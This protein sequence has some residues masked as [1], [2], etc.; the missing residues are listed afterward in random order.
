[1]NAIRSS[2]QAVFN[3]TWCI[4][5]AARVQYMQYMQVAPVHIFANIIYMCV[6]IN[7]N[8]NFRAVYNRY[9]GHVLHRIIGI[10]CIP[11]IRLKKVRYLL[12]LRLFLILEISTER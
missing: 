11:N 9:V 3:I 4:A 1:M 5:I 12:A 2:S 8:I 6:H 10:Y 7:A